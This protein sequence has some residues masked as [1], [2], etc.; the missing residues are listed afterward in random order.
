LK[1]NVAQLVKVSSLVIAGSSAIITSLV[2]TRDEA[3]RLTLWGTVLAVTAVLSSIIAIISQLLDDRSEVEKG[4][5]EERR[6]YGEL[7]RLAHPYEDVTVQIQIE[8]PY[9]Q[10]LLKEWEFP[11]RREKIGEGGLH[12]IVVYAVAG[13]KDATE[14][15]QYVSETLHMISL[16]LQIFREG[17]DPTTQPDLTLWVSNLESDG[18][19][20]RGQPYSRLMYN[21]QSRL[22]TAVQTVPAEILERR[23][24]FGSLIDLYG[25]HIV[26]EV[27]F[28][29]FR[30]HFLNFRIVGLKFITRSKIVI[31]VNRVTY[32]SG[33]SDVK[34]LGLVE[35]R[36]F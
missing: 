30:N 20:M 9:D 31:N 3:H 26:G 21:K 7:Q 24:T 14:A 32:D 2:E 36:S 18:N 17:A 13:R 5:E 33:E 27:D 4:L 6:L 35:P 10:P 8:V 28:W 25:A 11:Q 15:E 1:L 23:P 16:K 29:S 34:L 12:S 22:F 19:G